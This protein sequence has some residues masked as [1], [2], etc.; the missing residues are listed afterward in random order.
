MPASSLPPAVQAFDAIA[1][2][3]DARFSEWRSVAAQRRAVRDALKRAFAP[4][5]RLIEIG[6]GTGDD[7]IWMAGQGCEVLM[8]DASPAMVQ[9]AKAKFAGRPRLA[10]QV[11]SAEELETFA[12]GNERTF[13][14]A[15]SN[16]AGLNCVADLHPFARGLAQLVRPGGAALLVL[17]GTCPP[18]E[19][20]VEALHGRPRA[21]F[22]RF[23]AKPVHARLGSQEFTVRYHRAGEI[24]AAMA[25]WFDYEER[26]GI[27]VFVPPSAAEPWISR[28]PRLLGLLET[29]DRGTA[30]PLAMLGDHVLY[31]FTRTAKG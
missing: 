18:G 17:F 26:R 25:P 11:L 13:D 4:S 29:L 2:K 16:F 23:T 9:R 21:M 10:G 5:S 20:I 22:R 31:R 3:F 7:A 24:K 12:A 28:H 1:D 30:R 14:G 6:G 8:T 15:W 19:I 27:G